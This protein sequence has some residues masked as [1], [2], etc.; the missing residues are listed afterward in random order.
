MLTR[1]ELNATDRTGNH[2]HSE[3]RYHQVRRMIQY[4]GGEVTTL[5][6]DKLGDLDLPN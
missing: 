4:L 6:R 3:G 2:G 1:A 5:H